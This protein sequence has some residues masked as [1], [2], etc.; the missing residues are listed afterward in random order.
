[1]NTEESRVNTIAWIKHTRHSRHIMKIAMMTLTAL[2]LKN[3]P[4]DIEATRKMIHGIATA[5]A[6]PAIILAKSQIISAKGLVKIPTN[7]MTG[8]RGT[9]H[10]SRKGTSGQKMSF[11]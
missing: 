8:I 1:M 2:M 6:W 9:G 5:I 11:Q 10:F 4:T 7:S 3:T